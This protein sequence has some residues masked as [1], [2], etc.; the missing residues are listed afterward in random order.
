[1]LARPS[2][3]LGGRRGASLVVTLAGALALAFAACRAPASPKDERASETVKELAALTDD[4]IE[5]VRDASDKRAG[6]AAAQQALDAKQAELGP[7]MKELMAL[8]SA[9]LGDETRGDVARVL[10]ELPAKMAQLEIDL[11]AATA[12]DAT[13]AAAVEELT[14]DHEQLVRGR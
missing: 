3:A 1:V 2:F 6:V 12:S 9:E 7:R 5:T 13:L 11:R 10:V 8:P 14:A 4:I